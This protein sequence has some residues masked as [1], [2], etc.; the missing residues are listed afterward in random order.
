MLSLNNCT[1]L[2]Y[3]DSLY[4][5][6][7]RKRINFRGHIPKVNNME[8]KPISIAKKIL[9]AIINTT[10]KI[11]N[12]LKEKLGKEIQI[13]KHKNNVIINGTNNCIIDNPNGVI[14]GIFKNNKLTFNSKTIQNKFSGI[15]E[16]V[17][18]TD[19][20]SNTSVYIDYFDTKNKPI[21]I[22]EIIENFTVAN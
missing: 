17:T 22:K 8:K 13:S 4:K 6:N 16:K 9:K 14:V 7:S 2:T 12:F 15:L 1:S 11:I 19:K 3:K 10:K 18:I 5:I 21:T 20:D